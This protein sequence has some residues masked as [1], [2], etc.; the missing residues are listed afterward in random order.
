[1]ELEFT[2]GFDQS[3]SLPAMNRQCTN[4][5]P[6]FFREGE[7]VL[8]RLFGTPGQSQLATTGSDA[9]RGSF[10]MDGIP[11]FVN[12]TDFRRLNAAFTTTS[13]GTVNGSGKVSMA[14]N[15]TQLMIL[16]PG[17]NGYIW[18]K[19]TATF[20]QITDSD[21]VANGQPQIVIYVD[22][23]FM[24][25][26]DQKK[27]I[28]SSLRDGSSWAALDFGSADADPDPIVTLV[29]INNEAYLL[30]SQTIQSVE[31]IGGA[32]FPFVTTNLVIENGCFAPFS[33]VESGGT[34]WWIGGSKDDAPGIWRLDGVTPVKVSNT[35]VDL[36]LNALNQVQLNQVSAYTYSQ[37]NDIFVA[38]ELP[39]ETVV[40]SAGKW[41]KRQSQ[42]VDGAG[43]I[44]T[45]GWRST[46]F[47]T[48]Y[49]KLICFDTRDGRVGD[50]SRS[51][52]DEYGT[53]IQRIVDAKMIKVES[54][55]FTIP[56]VEIGIDAGVADST[57]TDPK[58]RMRK[59]RDSKVFNGERI[60]SMGLRGKTETR[61]VW[62]RNG[63]FSP[64]G[65]LRFLMSEKVRPV[66][67][68]ISAQIG[69][70]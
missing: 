4:W 13:L 61:V 2:D 48:A 21:F 16:V 37:D 28:V 51:F 6:K 20:V 58:I 65:T 17:G 50:V 36:L 24:C 56:R 31:N 1:M 41:H 18:N 11:Y 33:V 60:R 45:V 69:A 38:W 10:R 42:V 46:A 9:N 54:A 12:G 14:H 47:L 68:S 8:K 53:N 43:N 7:D 70:A 59:S 64:S 27:I 26:T 15:G 62:R 29:N 25:S 52:F 35:G 63:K 23:Y 19:N 40:F 30:G 34:F 55:T 39:G 5:Y 49:R 22:G 32:D 44:I 67:T 66:I 57:T 3:V